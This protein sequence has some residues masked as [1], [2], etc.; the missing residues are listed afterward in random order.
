MY[1]VATKYTHASFKRK[2]SLIEFEGLVQLEKGNVVGDD[3]GVVTLV[4]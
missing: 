4:L 3:A 1:S 2:C